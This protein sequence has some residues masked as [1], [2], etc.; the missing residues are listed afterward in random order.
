MGRLPKQLWMPRHAAV[1]VASVYLSFALVAEGEMEDLTLVSRMAEDAS[2]EY[3]AE[4]SDDAFNE[5]EGFAMRSGATVMPGKTMSDCENICLAEESCRSF[6]YRL[7]DDTCIWSTSS[8]TFDPDFMFAAKTS[9]PASHKKWRKFEGMSYR[10]Q[11]WTIIAGV[12]TNGC[13]QMCGAVAGCKAYSSRARDKLCLLG[14]KGITYSMDFNYFEKKGIPYEPFPLLPPGA[15]YSCTGSLCPAP[16]KEEKEAP[17]ATEDPKLMAMEGTVKKRISEADHELAKAESD[18]AKGKAEISKDKLEANEKVTKLRNKDESKLSDEERALI[19]K[20]NERLAK[21]EETLKLDAANQEISEK[22]KEAGTS[23]QDM[24]ERA[25]KGT[26]TTEQRSKHAAERELKEGHRQTDL[27]LEQYAANDEEFAAVRKMMKAKENEADAELEDVKKDAEDQWIDEREEKKIAKEHKEIAQKQGSAAAAS[28]VV[29]KLAESRSASIKANNDEAMKKQST[30]ASQKNAVKDQEKAKKM[31]EATAVREKETKEQQ[32]G[33]KKEMAALEKATKDENRQMSE[34][35]AKKY[36]T[37]ALAHE[38][39]MEASNELTSKAANAT[40]AQEQMKLKAEGHSENLQKMNEAE[41]VK[42]KEGSDKKEV[43]VKENAQKGAVNNTEADQKLAAKATE[44]ATKKEEIDQKAAEKAAEQAET[45]RQANAVEAE[46]EQVAAEKQG[47]EEYAAQAAEGQ[48]SVTSSQEQADSQMSKAEKDADDAEA[49]ADAEAKIIEKKSKEKAYKDVRMIKKNT[50]EKLGIVERTVVADVAAFVDSGENSV[51][52]DIDSARNTVVVKQQE[53]ADAL[54][55]LNS[56]KTALEEATEAVRQNDEQAATLAAQEKKTA[57]AQRNADKLNQQL[58]VAKASADAAKQVQDEGKAQQEAS[59]KAATEAANAAEAVA[60]AGAKV[61]N[62][63]KATADKVASNDAAQKA[64]DDAGGDGTTAASG[65]DAA[66]GNGMWDVSLIEISE[67]D[68]HM[69]S[70]KRRRLQDQTSQLD[71]SPAFEKDS[72]SWGNTDLELLFH[73]SL[74]AQPRHEALLGDA[75]PAPN[76]TTPSEEDTKEQQQ[77]DDDKLKE[78]TKKATDKA[79]KKT[80]EETLESAEEKFEAAVTQANE[81]KANVEAA[82]NAPANTAFGAEA[83]L[84]GELRVLGGDNWQMNSFLKFPQ[85]TLKESDVIMEAVL[86]LYKFGGGS[87]PIVVHSASCEW[88]RTDITF[89][90]AELNP[91]GLSLEKATVG[92]NDAVFPEGE[93]EWIDVKLHG[94]VVQNARIQGD[95]ICFRVSGGPAEDFVTLGSE[96]SNEKP[97]LILYVKPGPTAEEEKLEK[98][99]DALT[100]EDKKKIEARGLHRLAKMKEFRTEEETAEKQRIVDETNAPD[101]KLTLMK[102]ERAIYEKD[103]QYPS[104]FDEFAGLDKKS[105]EEER[106]AEVKSAVA[107]KVDVEKQRLED[108]DDAAIAELLAASN[109]EEGSPEYTD[110]QTRLQKEKSLAR[111]QTLA[112]Y[113]TDQETAVKQEMNAEMMSQVDAERTKKLSD[114]DAQIKD[115]RCKTMDDCRLSN[116]EVSAWEARAEARLTE[117]MAKYD[118]E[119]GTAPLSPHDV[120]TAADAAEQAAKAAVADETAADVTANPQSDVTTDQNGT[121]ILL[122]LT[123]PRDKDEEILYKYQFEEGR[124]GHHRRPSS[125]DDLFHSRGE[126]GRLSDVSADYEDLFESVSV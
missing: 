14:P 114:I 82:E 126:S 7:K 22:A 28:E 79:S 72:N 71:D 89:T 47:N 48:K 65:G 74:N 18:E 64:F 43:I 83:D 68:Q 100:D 111:E 96:N 12:D 94:D 76:A 119:N 19:A 116:D 54:T 108:E 10:T 86:R 38:E 27:M 58:T 39:A 20:D 112:N 66:D 44:S 80:A 73:D 15:S 32:G 115:T 110:E 31:A 52:T 103:A 123:D 50:M 121:Q 75:Q 13:E 125:T 34:V 24:R 5:V 87:G 69:N 11:G 91:G 21:E 29:E 40:K 63:A 99:A 85:S 53:E 35:E 33:I 106:D 90:I 104:A 97:E 78:N 81:A 49:K 37:L 17:P 93:K 117:E 60:N 77:K 41:L 109:L 101:G 25:T 36:V 57:E 98:A 51:G 56:A 45:Q 2:V 4:G 107:A 102:K 42:I 6:S 105:L 122:Q 46:K 120:M 16:K 8:L 3:Q 67:H 26:W 1:L 118:E 23:V 59:Q 61:V 88:T 9:N 95:H 84:E 30:E 70:K 124:T 55:A 113:E 62:E 92:S